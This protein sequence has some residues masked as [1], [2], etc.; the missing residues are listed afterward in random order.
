M[1]KDNVELVRTYFDAVAR[2]DIGAL[3]ALFSDELVWHQPG[4]GALS[5]TYS[6]KD[7]LFGLLGSFMERSGGTFR[8]DEIGKLL[9]NGDYV[10]TTLHFHAK[11]SGKDLSMSGIDV[12]RIED[13]KIHEVW[14]FSEDQDAED[15]FWG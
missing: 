8:I 2:G 6:G 9:A 15:A 13:G 11:A 1:S 10:A 3:G 14:L 4:K 12:L 5:G 7:A